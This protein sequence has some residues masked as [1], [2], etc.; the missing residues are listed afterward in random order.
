MSDYNPKSTPYQNPFHL[1]LGEFVHSFQ[2]CC[3]NNEEIFLSL[4]TQ[5]VRTER[6]DLV[7]SSIFDA[8][9][10]SLSARQLI[11][12]VDQSFNWVVQDDY[13]SSAFRLAFKRFR[14]LIEWRDFLMHGTFEPG[15]IEHGFQV[16]MRKSEKATLS[17][18]REVTLDFQHLDDLIHECDEYSVFS[19][20]TFMFLRE[21]PSYPVS[22]DDI[23]VMFREGDH[24]VQRVK[25]S[26][27][28]RQVG[29]LNVGSIWDFFSEEE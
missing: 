3:K 12:I 22:R 11:D 13:Y 7:R 27:P 23:E 2:E 1:K 25:S 17:G 29:Q 20:N 28:L 8:L 18:R 5:P 15:D 14:M 19:F 6:D 10:Q 26:F 24:C 21:M 9:I 16:L 4:L